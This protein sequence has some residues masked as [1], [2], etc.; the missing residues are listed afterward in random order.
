MVAKSYTV[1]TYVAQRLANM[2]SDDLGAEVKLDRLAFD[3]IRSLVLHGLLIHDQQGDTLVSAESISLGIKRIALKR[4]KFS[5]SDLELTRTD[6]RLRQIDE[7]GA[8]NLDF[9]L[10]YFGGSSPDSTAS[11]PEFQISASGFSMVDCHFSYLNTFADSTSFPEGFDMNNVQ[12]S[13]INGRIEAFSLADDT[14]RFEA[15]QLTFEER[16]GLELRELQALVVINPNAIALEKMVLESAESRLEGSLS[17]NHESWADYQ[18]FMSKVVWDAD[19]SESRLSFSDLG[20]FTKT[21]YN[22]NVPLY[23]SG[24]VQGPI[25]NLKGRGLLVIAGD[26]TTFRGNVDMMGLPDFDNT[27]ID[28]RVTQL[29]SNYND[30]E[31]LR[32]RIN[33]NATGPGLPL[34]LKRAGSIFFTGSFTGFPSN[35]VAF[36]ELTTEAG[37]L[38]L[39]LKLESAENSKVLVSSG[40]AVAQRFDIGRI[41]AEPDLGTVSAKVRIE[42]ESDEKINYARMTGDIESITYR[43][44]TYS[45]ITIDGE[46]NKQRFSGN[47]R[48]RDPN[49][50]FTFIGMVDLSGSSPMYDF[51]A[52]VHNLEL[53]T[54]NLIDLPKAFSFSSSIEMS[55]RGGDLTDFAGRLSA[56]NSF[57]CYGDTTL[58]L[59]SVVLSS[60]GDDANRKITL[61][62]DVVDIGLVGKYKVNELYDGFHQMLAIVMPSYRDRR[63]M[64]F[65]AEQVYD[66]SLN[67]KVQNA[68]TGVLVEGLGIAAQTSLYGSFDNQSGRIE[69]SLRSGEIKYKDYVLSDLVLNATKQGEIALIG[70][71]SGQAQISGLPI[72][73]AD[74]TVKASNDLVQVNF[75]WLNSDQS[76]SGEL[77]MQAVLYDFQTMSLLIDSLQFTA[78]KSTWALAQPSRIDLDTS[79]VFIDGFTL[80]NGEQRIQA[81]GKLGK[82]TEDEAMVLL[83]AIDLAYLDSLGIESAQDLQGI[84][85]ADIR[86]QSALREPIVTA[87]SSITGLSIDD[88]SIGDISAFST[89]DRDSN[90]LMLDGSLVKAAFKILDFQGSYAI[91]EELPLD[92][93][94]F[95]RDFDLD[96]INVLNLGV[97]DAFSGRANGSIDVQGALAAPVLKGEINFDK[98]RFRVDYLNTFFEFSD[99][100][101]VEEDW[102]GIDYKPIY[103][104]EGNKGFVVASVFH[105]NFSA[106]SYDISAEVE[107]FMVLNTDRSMNNI[108]YGTARATGF[109]QIGGFDDFLEIS[110]D[111]KTGR[112][113]NIRLPLDEPSDVTLENFVHFVSRD[114]VPETRR[115]NDLEGI[116]MRLN[117]EA[118][119]DAEIQ[120]IFDERAGDIIRGKGRGLVTLEIAPTGEF[121]MFGRYEITEGSYLFTLQNLI[122]KQFQVRPGGT[123]SWYGDPYEADI[124]ID[125]VYSLRTQLYPIMLENRE[126]YRTR[127][128]V[129]VVLN[130]SEKLTNPVIDFNIELP[131]TTDL[132]RSQL[133]SAVSTTQQL[134]QQVFA[135]L[136]LNRFL[137]VIEEDGQGGFGGLGSATTSDFIST[138]ISN[139]LSEIS[140][141]FEIGV[142]YRPGDQISNQEIAVALSTQ[143]FNER[144][145]VSGQ[146]GVTSPNEMQAAQGQSG[147]V[148]DFLLEYLITEEGKVRLRVFNETNPYENF[149]TAGSIYT[150]GVGLVLMEEFDTIEEFLDKLGSL[151]TKDKASKVDS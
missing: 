45:K 78:R 130:L 62:S 93:K 24:K 114:A 133:E 50:D 90:T 88:I 82:D 105:D 22:R 69:V 77:G 27:F 81:F 30:L 11:K 95:L 103:D 5:F 65:R 63:D 12:V 71:K 19:F 127:E 76:S 20:Y 92:G 49:V 13:D 94:L 150:Q 99:L 136:I 35:F 112:G 139:W 41:M 29:S 96:V 141:D 134:N 53:S 26:H 102:I 113:T 137:P 3:P 7:D 40:N 58:L 119:P 132:E 101:R 25:A 56:G 108:F 1:Q 31:M 74:L 138:Q 84:V 47:L 107:Q 144:V 131:Q 149:S 97:V 6:F 117:I 121:Q 68:V 135:L 10:D 110:I 148:G 57:I 118:T 37:N 66:F 14:I 128:D 61:T 142:N 146:F 151:F 36:G 106:W 15:R 126:R 2:M 100:V 23:L 28:L 60:L 46:L 111:A 72:E 8:T 87:K 43:G 44:Y 75:G 54:L 48:S 79:G 115:G 140:D 116:S 83:H 33:P 67:Y 109:L 38:E 147:I 145:L 52:D 85:E 32:S 42:A 122:N 125:A 9:I 124:D 91:G 98:A 34:E 16:S 17:L 55:G 73:N 104:Q 59:E 120:L 80:A 86:L 21:L 143:L 39:D 123:V 4:N 129:N 18:K 89:Y 64:N 70:L 51:R